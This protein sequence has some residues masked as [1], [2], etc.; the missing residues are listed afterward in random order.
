MTLYPEDAIYKDDR[1]G[2]FKIPRQQFGFPYVLIEWQS[3]DARY[4][5]ARG[6]KGFIKLAN[7]LKVS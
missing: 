1:V 6:A 4:M 3:G 2:L 5:S 7:K